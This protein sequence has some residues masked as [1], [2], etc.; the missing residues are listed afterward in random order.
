MTLLEKFDVFVDLHDKILC[1]C[2]N[3]DHPNIFQQHQSNKD[4]IRQA[5]EN[6]DETIK[7]N[8]ALRSKI[9]DRVIE[10]QRLAEAIKSLS[11]DKKEDFDTLEYWK[12]II[13]QE[14]G[15][16]EGQEFSRLVGI[17]QESQ[18]WLK[19]KKQFE[20]Q[21]KQIDNIKLL[22][23]QSKNDSVIT[24]PLFKLQLSNLVGNK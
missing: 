11:I 2:T 14:C 21:Q 15:L 22:L 13:R 20:T 10:I 4:C 18:A 24:Y 3:A 23:E 5:L 9:A 1:G 6:Y 8:F 7:H 17:H 16:V 19:N 12:S